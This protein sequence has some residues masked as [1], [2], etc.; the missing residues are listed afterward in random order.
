MEPK[1][2]KRNSNHWSNLQLVYNLDLKKCNQTVSFSENKNHDFT[3]NSVL[4]TAKSTTFS[5][6]DCLMW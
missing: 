4:D 6:T 2:N 3:Y 1:V 5:S